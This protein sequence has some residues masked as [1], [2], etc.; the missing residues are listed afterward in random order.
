[1]DGKLL[2]WI[3]SVAAIIAGFLLFWA[4]PWFGMTGL[5]LLVP[6]MLVA[7]GFTSGGITAGLRN[8]Y[9]IMLV[10]VGTIVVLIVLH[11]VNPYGLGAVT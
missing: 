6:P 7:G 3:L 1:M 5:L 10:F 4:G 2:G 11:Y 8:P 9:G